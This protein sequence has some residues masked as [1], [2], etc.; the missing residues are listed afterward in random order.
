MGSGVLPGERD[1][2]VLVDVSVGAEPDEHAERAHEGDRVAQ[3]R[4]QGEFLGL[5]PRL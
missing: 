5:F 3:E 2:L 4:F 1:A